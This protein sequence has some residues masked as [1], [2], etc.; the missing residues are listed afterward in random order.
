MLLSTSNGTAGLP[1]NPIMLNYLKLFPKPTNSNL[2]SN[3]TL[4]SN[5]TSNSNTYD[6]RIDHRFNNQNLIFARF[7]YNNIQ[8]FTPPAFGTVNG[9]QI[10]G[11]RYNFAGPATNIAQQYALG[12]THIF[13]PNL[14]LD[15]RAAFTRIN[16]QISSS[17]LWFECGPDCRPSREHDRFQSLC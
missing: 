17:E 14:L 10:S 11:G 6:A 1:I 4:S 2:A 13:T 12:Y 9:L 5:K 7:A 15:L 3:F 16:N 8:S